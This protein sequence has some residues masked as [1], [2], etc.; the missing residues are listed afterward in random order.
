[1]EHKA[2]FFSGDPT[3]SMSNTAVLLSNDDPNAASTKPSGGESDYYQYILVPFRHGG[4]L[5]HQ[6]PHFRTN[7][8]YRISSSDRATRLRSTTG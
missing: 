1:M 7:V 2:C 5:L 8:G 6:E 3:Q 4:Y